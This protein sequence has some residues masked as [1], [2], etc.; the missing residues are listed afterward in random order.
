MVDCGHLVVTG[1][2]VNVN[3]WNLLSLSLM[4]TVPVDVSILTADPCSEFMAVFTSS[5]DCKYC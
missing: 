5:N 4:W 2:P 1:S 3:V